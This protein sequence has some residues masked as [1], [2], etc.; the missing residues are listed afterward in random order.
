[1]DPNG[2]NGGVMV[3]YHGTKQKI[4]LNK[5]KQRITSNL[6]KKY[7][8]MEDL[9]ARWPMNILQRDPEKGRIIILFT[10]ERPWFPI[11]TRNIHECIYL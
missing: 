5:Q 11:P 8:P 3:I 4:T 2:P 9:T 7:T 10:G 1:M 6:R